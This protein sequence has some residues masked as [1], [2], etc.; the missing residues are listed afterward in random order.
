M[1]VNDILYSNSIIWIIVIPAIAFENIVCLLAISTRKRWKSPDVLLFSLILAHFFTLVLPLLLYAAVIIG[2]EPWEESACKFLVWCVIS[3]KI[4][5]SL[6]I[7][8]LSMDRVWTL[9]WPS[10]YRIHNTAKQSMRTVS[11]IWLFGL[12]IGTIPLLVWPV[13]DSKITLGCS[14]I[15][16]I[17]GYVYSVCIVVIILGSF[18]VGTA[19][20]TSIIVDL[21]FRQM[22]LEGA[23][24]PEFKQSIPEIVIESETGERTSAVQGSRE[25]QNR[26]IC[27]LVSIMVTVEFFV[28][29][30]PFVVIS[31]V[32]LTRD[33]PQKDWMPA[34]IMWCAISVTL[35]N[36]ILLCLICQRYRKSYT[37]LGMCLAEACGCSDSSVTDTTVGGIQRQDTID[38]L[39]NFSDDG[40]DYGN[41][42]PNFSDL[43]FSI[44]M[45]DEHALEYGITSSMDRDMRSFDRDQ[46]S[47]DFDNEAYILEEDG[48]K[49]KSK[50]MSS[51]ERRAQW[52]AHK[53][54]RRNQSQ[55]S[56][57]NMSSRDSFS[58]QFLSVDRAD[59]LR[60]HHRKLQRNARP[61]DPGSGRK[62]KPSDDSNEQTVHTVMVDIENG[63]LKSSRYKTDSDKTE[64]GKPKRGLRGIE[65]QEPHIRNGTLVTS[66]SCDASMSSHDQRTKKKRRSS[67]PLEEEGSAYSVQISPVKGQSTTEGQGAKS[68]RF[69]LRDMSGKQG[70]GDLYDIPE[71]DSE[72]IHD[73]GST[74]TP[75][76]K[77]L[78]NSIMS[79]QNEEEFIP[80]KPFEQ[81]YASPSITT[82][83]GKK[84]KRKSKDKKRSKRSPVKHL[85][86]DADGSALSQED[87]WLK[88]E[89][90]KEESSGFSAF[91]SIMSDTDTE[92]GAMSE[93]SG[94]ITSRESSIV[95]KIDAFPSIDAS[96][97]YDMDMIVIE[98]VNARPAP[99][100][101]LDGKDCPEM[102]DSVPDP[103]T[104]V[105][106]SPD[107][108]PKALEPHEN[109][110]ENKVSQDPQHNESVQIG[111]KS[112]LSETRDFVRDF[113]CCDDSDAKSRENSRDQ[114]D[115]NSSM[116]MTDMAKVKEALS[117]KVNGGGDSWVSQARRPR[118]NSAGAGRTS[119]KD[120]RER[121]KRSRSERIM[122]EPVASDS[123]Q[124]VLYL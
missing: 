89:I 113:A 48:G 93:H 111:D 122:M 32:A 104:P 88:N 6:Q 12:S 52:L 51:K 117:N 38:S 85:D 21:F 84:Q 78:Y 43:S 94:Y 77:Y 23:Q 92:D 115:D 86:S 4:V 44:D 25:T 24:G 33:E 49:S 112:D 103:K 101:S 39:D 50:S 68:S 102:P 40:V 98:Q 53:G 18:A 47:L 83:Q 70:S 26:Q 1:A 81:N 11:F 29:G 63:G 82:K 71:E 27:I 120:M 67:V 19:S 15:P 45:D 54:P 105:V 76:H 109:G 116:E 107:E 108:L 61:R 57:D 124:E 73:A 31:L 42:Y 80:D 5:N 36:P 106:E 110:V 123:S 114:T 37:K 75:I 13:D 64:R 30:I 91:N 90:L 14:V 60:N 56:V 22:P 8:F 41:H 69:D 46:E 34:S 35:I 74:H 28:N 96:I 72:E 97:E 87:Q 121:Y 17:G 7:C 3:F 66:Q 65:E 62:G 95:S 10:S 59:S 2:Q 119:A 118:A 99:Q 20:V 55:G 16:N 58:D 79:D 9:K 100:A